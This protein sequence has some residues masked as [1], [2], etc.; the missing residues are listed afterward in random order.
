[1][2]VL[3]N[4]A[5]LNGREV[6]VAVDVYVGCSFL[7]LK[8]YILERKDALAPESGKQETADV[9]KIKP[10]GFGSKN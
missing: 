10:K 4:P 3:A 7:E 8:Q 1:M 6:Q 9:D 5:L 2:L